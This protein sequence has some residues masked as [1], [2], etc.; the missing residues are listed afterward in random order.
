MSSL[1]DV[2][3]VE[4]ALRGKKGP[5]TGL[6]KSR[7]RCRSDGKSLLSFSPGSFVAFHHSRQLL[8]V[9]EGLRTPGRKSRWWQTL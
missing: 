6:A 5:A 3:C 1:N 2:G 9:F 4:I 7:T 8:H